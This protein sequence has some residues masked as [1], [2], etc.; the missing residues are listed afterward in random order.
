MQQA[1]RSG[2]LLL[3]GATWIRPAS[4]AMVQ[5]IVRRLVVKWELLLIR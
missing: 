4:G 3:F 1:T 5:R 2:G